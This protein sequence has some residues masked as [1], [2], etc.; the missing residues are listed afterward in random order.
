M[1]VWATCVWLSA[2]CPNTRRCS[3]APPISEAA[4]LAVQAPPAELNLPPV[5]T[6]FECSESSLDPPSHSHACTSAPRSQSVISVFLSSLPCIVVSGPASCPTG[7]RSLRSSANNLSRVGS[8]VIPRSHL[9]RWLSR[10]FAFSSDRSPS[11]LGTVSSSCSLR[12]GP[13]RSPLCP[14]PDPWAAPT[15]YGGRTA[16]GR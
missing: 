3:T 6:E 14:R 16:G 12:S 15:R 13:P 1:P 8:V 7:L 4:A 5:I 11:A 10:L 9:T 2:P